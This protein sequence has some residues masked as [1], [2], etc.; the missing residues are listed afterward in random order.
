MSPSP[1]G[2]PPR[3]TVHIALLFVQ[4]AFGSLAV[5]GKLAMSPRFGVSPPALAMVRILGGALVFVPA[6]LLLRSRRVRA[7]R[8]AAEL[9]LLALFGIVLNQALF[10]AGLRRT[11]P[12][13][14]TLLVAMIPVFTAA[15]AAITGRERLTGRAGAGIAVS[16]FGVLVLSGFALPRRGDVLVLLNAASYALY[17]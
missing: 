7:W 17:I 6:H 16:L 2:K 8:D 9:A 4:V 1:A 12:V 14:A 15:V 5:E 10:L 13:S 11:S 3:A